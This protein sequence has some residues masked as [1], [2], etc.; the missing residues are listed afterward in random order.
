MSNSDQRSLQSLADAM[1]RDWDDRAREDSRWYINTI[2]RNQED[3]EFDATGKPEVENFVLRDPLITKDRDLKNLRFLEIGCGIGRMTRH[4]AD[5]FGEV[6]GTDVSAEMIEQARERFR[7]SS[8]VF[9]YETNGLDFAAMPDDYF[10]VIFSV[11]VFQHV[12]AAEVVRSNVRDA[13]RVLRPGGVFKFQVCGINHPDYERMQKDTWTGTPFSEDEIRRA[14]RENGVRCLSIH[15]LGTQY[16]WAVFQKP[17]DATLSSPPAHLQIEFFGRSD[18]PEVKAIPTN[19]D[20]A[21]L[22]LI[23][24]GLDRNVEDANSV[25]LEIEGNEFLPHYVGPM[26]N[27]LPS[28]PS[29]V[30]PEREQPEVC[31]TNL[32]EQTEVCSPDLTEI[33][34]FTSTRMPRGLQN[35]RVK[36]SRGQFTNPVTIEFLAPQ[37][38]IPK[39]HMINNAV[40]GGVDIYAGGDKSVFRIFA[41]GMDEAA[42]VE[43]VRVHVNEHLLTPVSVTY[44]PANGFYLTIAKLPITISENDAE[45]RVQFKDSVSEPVKIRIL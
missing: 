22:T 43:N 44:L 26:W 34:L 41:D 13:C 25:S 40:D 4:F 19:G 24:S 17:A 37:A 3:Q 23:V 31:S 10:D 36:N 38:I 35:L 9:F 28:V 1:K 29:S 15:G 8:N 12:P 33:K 7:G 30:A 20:C 2:K 6:H 16:C 45:V 42:S 18:A 21:C 39:I 27:R 14:A 11:Y 5:L 32:I